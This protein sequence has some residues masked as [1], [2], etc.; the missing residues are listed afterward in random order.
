MYTLAGFSGKR[1][2]AEGTLGRYN[3]NRLFN[4]LKN[5]KSS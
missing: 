2:R 3:F 4:R 1:G 5:Q